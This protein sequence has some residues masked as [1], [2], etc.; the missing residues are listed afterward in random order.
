[1]ECG[2]HWLVYAVAD[3]GKVLTSDGVTAI[4]HRKSGSYY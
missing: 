2:D 3:E 4:N 1:M